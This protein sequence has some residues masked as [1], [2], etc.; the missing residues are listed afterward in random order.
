LAFGAFAPL[1][2]IREDTLLGPLCVT[3]GA[4]DKLKVQI[5]SYRTTVVVFIGLLSLHI[6]IRHHKA[7]TATLSCR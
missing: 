7:A 2:T 4:L 3:A 1:A 6:F 5:S